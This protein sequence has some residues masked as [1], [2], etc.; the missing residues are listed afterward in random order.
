MIQVLNHFKGNR[1]LLKKE[2]PVRFKTGTL[3][4]VKSLAGYLLPVQGDPL[5]FVIMLNGK[6]STRTR[7]RILGLLK[8]NLL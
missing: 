8:E 1:C 6:Y 7:G 4:D 2:G 5:P 3:H